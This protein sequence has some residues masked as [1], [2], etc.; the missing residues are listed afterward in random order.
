LPE[1]WILKGRYRIGKMIGAGGMSIVYRATDLET[2]ERVAV[3]M[4]RPEYMKDVNFLRQFR[5]EAQIVNQY[6]HRNIVRTLETGEED[7]VLFI[8]MEYIEGMTLKEYIEERAPLSHQQAAEIGMQLCDALFYSHSHQLIHRDIKPQNILMTADGTIKVTDFGIA[9]VAA[10]SSATTVNAQQAIGSVHYASPE[11]VRGRQTTAQSD[12]YSA[13]CVLYEMVTGH[14]P[15]EAET[16]V[17]IALKQLHDEPVLPSRYVPDIPKSLE[18]IILKALEK[19]PSSRYATAREMDSDLRRSLR[20]PNGAFVT[21]ARRV[22]EMT[23]AIPMPPEEEEGSAGAVSRKRNVGRRNRFLVVQMLLMSIIL[24]GL[25]I[26]VFL[27]YR[28][29]G[30]RSPNQSGETKEVPVVESLSV[31]EAQQRLADLGL[32]ANLVEED[33]R[34]VEE[35]QIIRSEPAAGQQIALEDAVTLYVSTGL[36]D[37]QVPNLFDMTLE[38]AKER[39][40]QNG[41]ILGEVLEISDQTVD[42]GNVVKQ[43]PIAGTTCDEGSSVDLWLRK[44]GDTVTMPM[45]KVVGMMEDN[46]VSYLQ[47]QGLSIGEIYRVPSSV[48]AAGVVVQQDPVEKITIGKGNTVNLWISNGLSVMY[49]KTYSLAVTVEKNNTLV[50]VYALTD[51]SEILIYQKVLDQGEYDVAVEFETRTEGAKTLVLYMDQEEKQRVTVDVRAGGS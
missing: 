51:D 25:A 30:G 43:D 14:V 16:P 45:P 32:H 34:D 5:K 18:Q 49:K 3:K 11:Q 9:R 24:A 42:A 12:I 6:Q 37:V 7:G 8:V 29:S 22:A 20:E 17:S 13:G 44:S 40:R 21:R 2:L 23:Q 26:A 50:E 15:F 35:G 27:L 19:N 46:A 39:L 1:E 33:S 36:P 41:L 10:A 38:D 47:S 4:L 28:I 31:N 48:Y